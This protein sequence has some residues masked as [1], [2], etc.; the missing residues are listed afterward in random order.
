MPRIAVSS[1]KLANFDLWQ[2]GLSEVYMVYNNGTN[3]LP[4]GTPASAVKVKINNM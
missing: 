2:V 4:W 1:A 3:I